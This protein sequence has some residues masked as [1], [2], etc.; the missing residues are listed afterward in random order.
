MGTLDRRYVYLAMA[1][2]VVLP[3]LAPLNFSV[4]PGEQT[5]R[6]DKALDKAIASDR[7]IMVGVDFG[8]QTMAEME[9]ILL[10]VMYKL[11]HHKK[12]VVFLT[13]LPEASGLMHRYF[14]KM[15]KTYGLVYGT[16]Y[17]YLGF[18]QSY[19]VAIYSMGTSI[20]NYVRADDRGTAIEKIPLMQDMNKLSD[21]S[22]V[23]NVASNVMP[24]HWLTWGVAP[25]GIDFLMACTAT[26][27]TNYLPYV[28]T[29]Q[30]KGLIAG[31]RAGAEYEGMLIDQGVLKEPGE[32]S[33]GLDSQS[34]ALF[35][36]VAFIIIG[37]IG[38]FAGSRR[39]KGGSK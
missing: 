4:K 11:F 13:F 1:F 2:A 33:R 34:L 22:A 39:S 24:E 9:P 17:V 21:F 37:N 30:V 35:A 32:A 5:L 7:P 8:P 18:I 36:I 28:Q 31:G 14:A 29:G 26:N 15:E 10:D 23:I 16:D 3:F 27:V 19:F 25:F 38:Y 6:F 12:K 20:K